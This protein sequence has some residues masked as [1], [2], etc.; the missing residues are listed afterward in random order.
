LLKL[1]RFADGRRSP[2]LIVQGERPKPDVT[3]SKGF[4]LSFFYY[5]YT[6]P[7]SILENKVVEEEEKKSIYSPL[8]R[9]SD[10]LF[11]DRGG[12]DKNDCTV[13]PEWA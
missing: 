2:T 11:K 9:L 10:F 13:V 7:Y 8:G 12:L 1:F 6:L 5:C 3:V 4:T